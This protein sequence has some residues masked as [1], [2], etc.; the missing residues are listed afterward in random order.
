LL[1]LLIDSILILLLLGM[2]REG[3]LLCGG[4]GAVCVVVLDA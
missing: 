2:V 4:V 1:L 3:L